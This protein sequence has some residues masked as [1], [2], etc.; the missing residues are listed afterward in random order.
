MQAE[1]FTK[2]GKLLGAARRVAVLTGAGVSAESGVPTFR[3]SSGLWRKFDPGA[4]PVE[5]GSRGLPRAGGRA[6]CA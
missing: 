5:G 2:F 4:A 3:S 6:D 1:A